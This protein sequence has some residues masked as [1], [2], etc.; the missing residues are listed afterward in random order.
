MLVLEKNNTNN[1]QTDFYDNFK[2]GILGG[3]QLGRMLI[4]QAINYNI[5]ISILDPDKN[6]PCKDIANN[7][8]V[9]SLNDYDTVYAFGKQV[10]M[11]TIEIEHVNVEALRKLEEE[12]IPVFPQPSI[13]KMIQDK[14]LQKQFYSENNIPTPEYYLIES[15]SDILKHANKFPFFQKLRK[16]GYDGKGVVK[17]SDSTKLN[18]AF[19]APSVLE[20][21]INFKK[22]I[23]VIVARNQQGEIKTFPS[24]E[25]DFNPEANLVEFLF[26]PA[27]HNVEVEE[28]A[29]EIAHNI[30]KKLGIVGLLAVEMFITQNDEVLVN[31][32]AP[33]PHNSGHQTIEGNYTSQYEQHLRAILDLPLGNTEI[34]SPSVMINLLGEKGYDGNAQY[35]GL[36]EVLKIKGAHVHLYGKKTTK[37]FR[38]MGHV[39]VVDEHIHL[40]KSKA[41]LI[42]NTLKVIA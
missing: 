17:L 12:G 19:D 2:L 4:Q 41:I 1:M 16:G 35:Q 28:K 22:E 26:S 31:E 27:S 25:C 34:I 10:N 37:P 14:G 8:I 30:A 38:K 3:G 9:G 29:Q 18:D 20:K 23:S 40:A 32:I 13:L 6:A 21:I 11:L 7:F 5:H 39:T 42:K 24:V 33:R 36:E 15:K